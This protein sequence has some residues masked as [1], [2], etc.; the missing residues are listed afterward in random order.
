VQLGQAHAEQLHAGDLLQHVHQARLHQLE[1]DQSLAKQSALRGV[2]EGGV[3]GGTAWP[4]A[5]NAHW[6]RVPASTVPVSIAT[7]PALAALIAGTLG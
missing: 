1:V 6:L 2:G 4:S 7:R 5:L 3:V